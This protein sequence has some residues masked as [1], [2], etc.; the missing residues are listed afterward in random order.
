[1]DDLTILSRCG[2]A[3]LAVLLLVFE[4]REGRAGHGG[5]ANTGYEYYTPDGSRIRIRH[6][7]GTLYK[8]YVFDD[9]PVPV[10]QD[11]FGNCFT[12]RAGSAQEAEYTIDELYAQGGT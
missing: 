2:I 10:T 3:V 7:A 1:M 11:R 8:V 6:V 9:C 12:I 4:I 5:P